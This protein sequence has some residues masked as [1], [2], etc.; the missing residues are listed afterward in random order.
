MP[1]IQTIPRMGTTKRIQRVTMDALMRYEY[2]LPSCTDTYNNPH[3]LAHRPARRIRQRTHLGFR[4]LAAVGDAHDGPAEVERARAGVRAVEL[5]VVAHL[6]VLLPPPGAAQLVRAARG[7]RAAG[8]GR[9]ARARRVVLWDGHRGVA[10]VQE[11][12]IPRG[13]LEGLLWGALR[14][15]GHGGAGLD[16][17]SLLIIAAELRLVGMW[18]TVA[19]GCMCRRGQ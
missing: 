14:W 9:Q 19:V 7:A 11:R 13:A 10:L 3:Q 17:V 5:L 15:V 1:G 2:T 12:R 8:I 18:S 16:A 6:R 4:L